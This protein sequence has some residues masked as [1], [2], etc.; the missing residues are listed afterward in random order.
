MKYNAKSLILWMK[1]KVKVKVNKEKIA[2]CAIW[3]EMF[4][5]MNLLFSEF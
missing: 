4:E 1:V 5:F 2:T 3:L